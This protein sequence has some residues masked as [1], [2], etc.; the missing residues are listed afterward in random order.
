MEEIMLK[1][2]ITVTTKSQISSSM[3]PLSFLFYR[4][5]IEME[6]L[7]MKVI[8]PYSRSQKLVELEGCLQI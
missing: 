4:M 8:C 3:P 7:R 1:E 6:A 2:K 5:E